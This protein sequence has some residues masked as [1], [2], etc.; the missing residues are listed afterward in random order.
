MHQRC[1]ACDLDF[2]PEPGYFTGAMYISYALAVPMIAALTG[3]V[4]LVAPPLPPLATVLIAGGLFLPFVPVTFRASRVL[5]IH[6]DRAI[7]PA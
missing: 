5:W 3:L 1:T 2:E 4:Y 6:L 7:D